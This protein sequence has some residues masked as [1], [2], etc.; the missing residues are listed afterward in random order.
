MSIYKNVPEI[1]DAKSLPEL[2]EKTQA[3]IE[4]GE[5]NLPEIRRAN[6]IARCEQLD[7]ENR[8]KLSLALMIKSYVSAM[9][10]WYECSARSPL[11]VYPKQ[12]G[13]PT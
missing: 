5:N 11:M 3:I 10:G 1:S 12:E 9:H 4:W 6:N 8:L 7:R 2:L 13:L